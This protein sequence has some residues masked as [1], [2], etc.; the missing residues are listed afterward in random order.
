MSGSFALVETAGISLYFTISNATEELYVF[1]NYPQR[2]VIAI[3]LC[4]VTTVGIIGNGL[5]VM[6]ILCSRKLRSP[7]NW[8]VVN[9]SVADFV[10][11]LFLPF[12][13][14]AMLAREGWPLVDWLCTVTGT[15]TLT[16]LG[17]SVVTLALIANCRW[18][19]LTHSP[20]HFYVHYRLRNICIMVTMSWVYPFL[21]VII[22]HVA[23][24][25]HLGYSENYKTC[26]QDT[27]LPN[28][29]YYSLIPAFGVIMPVFFAI[30]IIYLRIFRF[31]E[32][33]NKFMK[34]RLNASDDNGSRCS[35]GKVENVNNASRKSDAYSNNNCKDTEKI[36]DLQLSSGNI[37]H[38]H[39]FTNSAYFEEKS[40][41][42][43][44]KS[45]AHQSERSSPSPRKDNACCSQ[46]V[47]VSPRQSVP[48][49]PQLSKCS[50]SLSR[51]SSRS[52]SHHHIAVTKRL[53]LV[54]F[55]F[56]VC[57][58]PFALCMMIPNSDPAIPWAN[59]LVVANS[60]INPILYAWT[61]PAFRRV[62]KNILLCRFRDIPEPVQS[63]RNC[64]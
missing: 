31:I 29:D 58:F 49:E 20:Y 22:P 11:C 25:V 57:M 21:L 28:S 16:C 13:I 18:Y 32:R 33:H 5:V 54:V 63:L 45:D 30:V 36:I 60:C 41:V 48:P 39:V 37:S 38:S 3:A 55:T 34:K 17:T 50:S 51:K 10:T 26:Q 19:H 8:F 40:D 42:T 52:E 43:M 23:G 27:T 62:M 61:M 15:V 7:T 47:D 56:F 12:D 59:L 4:I 24:L 44:E 6:S 46:P 9:L 64:L 2:V 35:D 53:V 1:E 14:V